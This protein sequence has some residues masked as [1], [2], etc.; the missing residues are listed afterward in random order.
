[1]KIMLSPFHFPQKSKNLLVPNTD[2]FLSLYSEN[3]HFEH[4]SF[5]APCPQFLSMC[6]ILALAEHNSPGP[7][8]CHSTDYHQLN[9]K[10]FSQQAAG[11]CTIDAITSSQHLDAAV[12]RSVREGWLHWTKAQ[13]RLW[14]ER[15]KR[16]HIQKIRL[17]F[18]IKQSTIRLIKSLLTE[19]FLSKFWELIAR[20]IALG[21]SGRLVRILQ[22]DS[23]SLYR[24]LCLHLCY[25]WAPGWYWGK[26][27]SFYW[28]VN[29]YNRCSC[30]IFVASAPNNRTLNIATQPHYCKMIPLL[31]LYCEI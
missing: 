25:D 2:P 24:E 18:E 12:R 29:H 16:K 26:H 5:H 31:S 23:R 21:K 17:H 11:N 6:F 14:W 15:G 4:L 27:L 10:N 19:K 30:S 28:L 9:S 3:L 22:T 8:K 13:Q 20:N 7:V 1:M